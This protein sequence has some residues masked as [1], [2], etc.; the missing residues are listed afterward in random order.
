MLKNVCEYIFYEKK[1]IQTYLEKIKTITNKISFA[2]EICSG[3]LS[4]YPVKTK[5]YFVNYLTKNNFDMRNDSFDY[6]LNQSMSSIT[7]EQIKSKQEQLKSFQET[8]DNIRRTTTG[9]MWK[10]DLLKLKEQLLKY[11]NSLKRT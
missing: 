8:L 2:K 6:L 11:R 10:T 7:T 9:Q 5:E 3:K 4:F 1:L